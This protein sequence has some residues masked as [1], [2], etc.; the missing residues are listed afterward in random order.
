[1]KT[2]CI[3]LPQ[4]LKRFTKQCHTSHQIFVWENIII[5]HKNILLI[6]TYSY[7]II[8]LTELIHIS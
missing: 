5:F 8:I 2:I 3:L 1:M 6:L 4:I 7:Y